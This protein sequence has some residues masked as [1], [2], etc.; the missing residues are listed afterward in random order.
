MNKV[1]AGQTEVLEDW[2]HRSACRD[3]ADPE[4]FFPVGTDGPTLLQIAEAK[5]VCVVCPVREDCL[6]WALETGQD[7]GVWGG[8][9]EEERRDLNRRRASAGS[10]PRAVA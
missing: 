2:R 4:L 3:A 7:A 6:S 1:T 5:A 8:L 10:N 9:T